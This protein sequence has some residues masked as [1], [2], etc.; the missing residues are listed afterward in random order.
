LTDTVLLFSVSFCQFPGGIRSSSTAALL[1]TS[2]VK[3]GRE[4]VRFAVGGDG[5]I[6]GMLEV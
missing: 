4:G 1:L 3:M 5:E 6:E 2:T